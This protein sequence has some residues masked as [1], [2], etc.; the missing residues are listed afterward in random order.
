MTDHDP[1]IRDQP[2]RDPRWGSVRKPPQLQSILRL[3][4]TVGNQ[5]AQRLLG[6]GDRNVT[7]TPPADPPAP[8]VR[9]SFPARLSSWFTR[10]RSPKP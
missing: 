5:A 9:R 1:I 4:R 6:I 7:V 3:Q 8:L 2:W 10:F